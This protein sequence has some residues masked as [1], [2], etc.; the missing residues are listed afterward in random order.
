MLRQKYKLLVLSVFLSFGLCNLMTA[1]ESFIS[2]EDFYDQDIDQFSYISDPFEV[3]NR[4]TF[5]INDIIYSNIIQPLADTYRLVTPDL[6]EEG[7]GNFFYNVNYPV[8][9]FSNLFQGRFRGMWVETVRFT[10]NSTI[11]IVGFASPAD[12]IDGFSSGNAEDLGQAFGAL[13]MNEGPYLVLPLLGPSN[14]RDLGGL[15]AGRI[16]NP[17]KE[18]SSLIDDW[19]LEY[20]LS[21]TS[22]DFVNNSSEFLRQYNQLKDGAIDPYSSVKNGYTQYRRNAI[23]NR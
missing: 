8:R 19:A 3:V 11:G 10:V 17:V 6:I 14:L 22:F 20:R 23:T 15:I 4:F 9:L 21:F 2:E 5:R 7:A 16:I 1:Q 13:G 12:K 18:P